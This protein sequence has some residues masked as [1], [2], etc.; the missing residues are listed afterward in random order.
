VSDEGGDSGCGLDKQDS[1]WNSSDSSPITLHKLFQ[2]GQLAFPHLP[3]TISNSSCGNNTT[4]SLHAPSYSLL[5]RNLSDLQSSLR[6]TLNLQSDLEPAYGWFVVVDPDSDNA[7]DSAPSKL[8]KSMV[9]SSE[10]TSAGLA[11]VAPTAPQHTPAVDDHDD[12]V[13]WAKA[14]DTVDDVLGDFF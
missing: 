6:E 11:F 8:H 13:M 4:N 7:R 14:A 10:S 12:E 9:G 5:T 1:S 2:A 3:A